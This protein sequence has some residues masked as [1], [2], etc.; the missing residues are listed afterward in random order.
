MDFV[1]I[2]REHATEYDR[3]VNAE[4]CDQQ[5][6]PTIAQLCP[7]HGTAALDV[8]AGTGRVSRL[9]AAGGARLASFDLSPAMLA[10]ARD[11]LSQMGAVL[12]QAD[13]RQL[14]IRSAWA[15]IA[16]AGWVFGH[17]TAWMAD[18]WQ[19]TIGQAFDEMAR[20][21]KPGG[22]LI[23]IETMGTGH[24]E[25]AAPSEGLAAYYTWMENARGFNRVTLRTDYRFADVE[26]A[27]QVTGFF[28]GSAFAD[29]V[30]R[31]RWTRVPECTGLWWKRA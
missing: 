25:P 15:D 29:Q 8:G 13:G 7:L 23:I 28:F 26:T 24:T 3:L 20:A 30:R 1:K 18:R 14:P 9:L 16:V 2:Y 6:L 12:A 21:L 22:T 19:T 11:H 10:V 31:E 27:A 5:L 17:M 4:D